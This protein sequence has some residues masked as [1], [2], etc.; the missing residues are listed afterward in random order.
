MQEDLIHTRV[1]KGQ[2]ISS[3]EKIVAQNR[4]A[5]VSMQQCSAYFSFQLPNETTRVTYLLDA[6]H[7]SDPP[8][9]AA[10]ALV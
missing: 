10:M 7:C 8:L 4:N 9:Q 3:L 2:S 5:F 1:W 6:I